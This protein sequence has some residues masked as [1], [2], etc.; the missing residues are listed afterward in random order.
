M[1][2]RLVEPVLMLKLLT[3]F[4]TCKHFFQP[5]HWPTNTHSR[6]HIRPSLR[7]KRWNCGSTPSSSILHGPWCNYCNVPD[8]MKVLNNA[9]AWEIVHLF[10]CST[11]LFFHEKRG[12]KERERLQGLFALTVWRGSSQGQFER[13]V[14]TCSLYRQL[15]RG[16]CNPVCRWL[17]VLHG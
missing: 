8:K 13:A 6:R 2:L 7:E 14:C 10:I 12:L 4:Q 3:F 5:T 11:C 17:Q 1:R 15:V 9:Y 16:I